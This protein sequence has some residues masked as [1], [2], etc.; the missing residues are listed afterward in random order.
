MSIGEEVSAAADSFTLCH[1][2]VT[3]EDVLG[4]VSRV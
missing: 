4:D 2:Q 1:G 3:I